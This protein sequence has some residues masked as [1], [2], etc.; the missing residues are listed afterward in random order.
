MDMPRIA[1]TF[2]DRIT[3]CGNLD[4]RI[5]AS[6]DRAAIDEEIEKKIKPVLDMGSSFIVHSDHSIPPDVDHDTL[7]YLFERGSTITQRL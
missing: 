5:V 2:G 3:F 1:K 6:N 4:I 7:K